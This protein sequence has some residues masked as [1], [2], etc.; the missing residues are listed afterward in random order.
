MLSG[1]PGNLPG[2][3]LQVPSR[4]V[5]SDTIRPL[6]PAQTRLPMVWLR[7]VW[8]AVAVIVL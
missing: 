6:R 1:G 3:G 5:T 4:G 8:R 7:L 2:R